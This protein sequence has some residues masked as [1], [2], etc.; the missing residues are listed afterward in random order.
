MLDYIIVGLAA[1]FAS[2]LTLFSGFGLGT[3]L[4]P[5]L[6]LFFPLP[7]AI[8]ATAVVHLANN[9]FKLIL[10]GRHAN[11]QVVGRFGSAAALAAVPGAL[12]LGMLS[13]L[14][15]VASY[16]AFGATR[17]IHVIKLVIGVLIVVFAMLELRSKTA[18]VAFPRQF[19]IVGGLLSGF[20]G[21][22]SGNQGALRAAFLI[23]AGLDKT[24]FVGTSV[25][26]AIIVD[27]IR[28]AAYGHAFQF[29]EIAGDVA[30]MVKVAMLAAFVGA[31]VGMRLLE[32]A[33]LRFVQLTVA[34]VMAVIG[35]GLA[36]GII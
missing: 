27:T 14:P 17:E 21:G 4:M 13:D 29:T 28:I 19:L 9:L 8:A 36:G 35:T 25:V 7:I 34:A 15:V 22:L 16:P 3:I 18:A 20:F 23:R 32:R 5:V 11:W 31:Y 12:V 24:A 1:L 10:V 26:T 2:G 6:A 30:D 33:T